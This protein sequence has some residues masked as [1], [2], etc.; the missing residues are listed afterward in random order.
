VEKGNGIIDIVTLAAY[1]RATG[2]GLKEL[3]IDC[4]EYEE[5]LFPEDFD[6]SP[7]SPEHL[8]KVNNLSLRSLAKKI[9]C[10]PTTLLRIEQ[11]KNRFISFDLLVHLDQALM[12]NGS[13]LHYY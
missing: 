2:L 1:G 10:S 11:E 8:R 13:L 3:L 7:Q 5:N 12:A 4:S 6:S 9:N